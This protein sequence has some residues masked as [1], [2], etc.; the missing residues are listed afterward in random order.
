M[1]LPRLRSVVRRMTMRQKIA[2]VII[3]AICIQSAVMVAR[4]NRC[5]RL[6]D[7][8]DHWKGFQRMSPQEEARVEAFNGVRIVPSQA[9]IEWHDRMARKYTYAASHPW[10]PVPPD[11]PEPR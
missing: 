5:R 10:F 4:T 7:Y 11:P 9:N 2:F 6:A 3:L 1:L 8:H